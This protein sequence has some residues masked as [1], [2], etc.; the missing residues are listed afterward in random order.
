MAYYVFIKK[1]M[2][3]DTK[4]EFNKLSKTKKNSLNK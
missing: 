3:K 4:L 2:V 1:A